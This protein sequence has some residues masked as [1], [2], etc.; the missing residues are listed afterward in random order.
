MNRA[1]VNLYDYSSKLVNLH[2]YTQID[3][4]HFLTKLCK[5]YI[6]FYHTRIAVNDLI[7]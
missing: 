4:G 7:V 5:F 6:F 1:S 2:D 3:V